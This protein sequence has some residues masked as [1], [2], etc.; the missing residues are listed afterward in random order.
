VGK[1]E[2]SVTQGK[3]I[4]S[5]DLG[6]PG[7]VGCRVFVDPLRYLSDKKKG[8]VIAIDSSAATIHEIGT[9][10]FHFT[11][12]PQ[13][14]KLYESEECKRLKQL[15]PDDSVFF[16][17]ASE[18]NISLQLPQHAAALRFPML[19]PFSARSKE[20]DVAGRLLHSELEPWSSSPGAV[21]VEVRFQDLL[22]ALGFDD[23]LGE[24]CIPIAKLIENGEIR[25]WFRVLEVGSLIAS[26]V[27]EV[28]KEADDRESDAIGHDEQHPLVYV[29]LKWIPPSE[30]EKVA[31][32]DHMA[33]LVIQ[34]ELIRYTIL[35]QKNKVDLVGSSIG[36][37]NTV[38][39]LR[40][41]VQLIQNGLGAALDVIESTRNAFNFTVRT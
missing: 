35:A 22:N 41:N 14:L 38:R 6:L 23:A 34:E 18:E 25:G 37:F 33:S 27:S 19:Q 17:T 30:P 31:E 1:I 4:R 21:V 11:Q 10:D 15:L 7:S 28:L 16:G 32:T 5:K 39:G 24:V 12:Q 8:Q 9:T 20:L 3:N 2:V 29:N 40:G 13:W 26:P 36:A